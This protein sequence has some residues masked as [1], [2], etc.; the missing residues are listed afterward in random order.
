MVIPWGSRTVGFKVTM[1]V[2]FMIALPRSYKN[3]FKN[4]I[5]VLHEPR[6]IEHV[7]DIAWCK[8][9]LNVRIALHFVFERAALVPDA[10][11]IALHPT[12]G[13]LA[14]YVFRDQRQ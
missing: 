5:D 10:H 11:R 7:L 3:P 4:S 8:R 14:R 13:I 12:V 1:T 6:G 9:L 2:A